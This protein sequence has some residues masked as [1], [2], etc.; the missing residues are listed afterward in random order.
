MRSSLDLGDRALERCVRCRLEGSDPR[1]RD[2]CFGQG[3]DL[4]QVD[5]VLGVVTPV[6]GGVTTGLSQEAFVVIDPDGLG[7]HARI[8]G[9]LT[10]GDHALWSRT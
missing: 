6:A 1:E 4:D 3:A 2:S 5:G 8:P 9:E 7:R 10:D